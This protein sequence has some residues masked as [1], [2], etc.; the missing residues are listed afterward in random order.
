M[1]YDPCLLK[2]RINYD[3]EA[4]VTYPMETPFYSREKGNCNLT[5][6]IRIGNVLLIPK[7]KCNLLSVSFLTRDLNCTI[8]FYPNFY[9]IQ[10]L[11]EKRLIGMGECKGGIYRMESMGEENRVLKFGTRE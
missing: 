9:I 4:P 6:A 5:N 2:K 8:T 11:H 10:D 1:I 7:C 3:H